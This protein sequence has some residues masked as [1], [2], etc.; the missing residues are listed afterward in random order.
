MA[1]R[2]ESRSIAYT[3]LMS[4]RTA[5][6]LLMLVGI[7]LVAHLLFSRYGFNPTD[8]GF[9]LAYSRRILDGQIPHRDFIIIRPFL[10]PLLHTPVVALG[11]PYTYW[12]SRLVV[13]AQFVAIVWLW[14]VVIQRSIGTALPLRAQFALLLLGVMLSAHNFPLMAW[15]TT[16]GLL[17]LALGAA[18]LSAGERWRLP[19]Y[20]LIGSAVLCKQSFMLAL[21][22]SLLITG[23]WRDVRY[24]ATGLLPGALYTSF[25]FLTGGLTEAQ[26]QLL[27]QT[28]GVLLSKGVIAYLPYLMISAWGW[29]AV[30]LLSRSRRSRL[31]LALLIGTPLLL[32][33]I[34]FV[35][36]SRRIMFPVGFIVFA[37]L[38]GF[39]AFAITRRALPP[40]QTRVILLLLVGGWSASLSGGYASPILMAGPLMI[41]LIVYASAL[42]GPAA[43]RKWIQHGFVLGMVLL[44]LAF[45]HLR[46]NH[47]YR[48]RPASEMTHHLGD[49]LPGAHLILTNANTYRY[50]EDLNEA[51]KRASTI[52][53]SYALIPDCPGCWVQSLQPNPLPIDWVLDLYGNP[54]TTA[55]TIDALEEMR[56]AGGVVI[57]QEVDANRIA[58]AFVP[59]PAQLYDVVPYVRQ[60]FQFVGAT[61]F[62][63][64]YR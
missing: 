24:W 15:S 19:A 33:L 34:A 18:A 60:R 25:V 12:L 58:N 53:H 28:E 54:V 20:A 55:Q 17:L 52:G 38:A 30:N 57:L 45:V 1:L 2:V 27:S 40:V 42:A 26:T 49:L 37:T 4:H 46:L 35:T 31:L 10:S 50:F 14:L 59:L 11:G 56:A 8:D 6:T 5:I 7:T 23:D 36:G 44:T 41:A 63:T 51:V 29:L 62:F 48:E 64:L 16:D 43:H 61:D 39:T 13:W 3:R 21:P 47:I 22:L 32:A 9:T